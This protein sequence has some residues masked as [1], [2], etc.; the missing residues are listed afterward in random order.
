MLLVLG[1]SSVAVS[2]EDLG[3]QWCDCILEM[4]KKTGT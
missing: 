1:M 2:P 4:L 3:G